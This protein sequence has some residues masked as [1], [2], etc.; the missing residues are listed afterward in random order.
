ME[1]VVSWA[2]AMQGTASHRKR[3]ARFMAATPRELERGKELTPVADYDE[4][5]DTI[6]GGSCAVVGSVL[7][8]LC[9]LLEAGVAAEGVEAGVDAQPAG[10]EVVRDLQQRLQEVER[11]LAVPHQD[12]DPHDLVLDVRVL[13][14]LPLDPPERRTPLCLADRLVLAAQMGERQPQEVAGRRVPGS[15]PVR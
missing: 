7:R 3:S 5:K 2:R 9:E 11:L 10:R 13:G 14:R 1:P 15:Y 4:P 6:L 12:V 8:A